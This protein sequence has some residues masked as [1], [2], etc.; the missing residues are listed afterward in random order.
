MAAIVRCRVED[1]S[2]YVRLIASLLPKQILNEHAAE[3]GEAVLTSLTVNFVSRRPL[4][5]MTYGIF[6]TNR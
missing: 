6:R 2:T 1:L 3:G 5:R 4:R